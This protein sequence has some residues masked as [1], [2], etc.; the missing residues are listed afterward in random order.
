MHVR[1]MIDDNDIISCPCRRGSIGFT[2]AHV[3]EE[4]LLDDIQDVDSQ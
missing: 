3:L 2:D 1:M 4:R